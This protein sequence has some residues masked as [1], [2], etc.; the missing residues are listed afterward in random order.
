MTDCV[1]LV[2][3]EGIDVFLPQKVNF[4]DWNM[5]V[6]KRKKNACSFTFGRLMEIFKYKKEEVRFFF[7]NW[8]IDKLWA[9]L[10]TSREHID[11]LQGNV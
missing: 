11:N 6:G 7:F 1:F 2:R 8:P 5:E 4:T 9:Y 10:H 3:R